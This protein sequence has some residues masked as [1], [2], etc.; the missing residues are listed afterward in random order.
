MEKGF[1]NLTTLVL[2][3]RRLKRDV[4]KDKECLLS[5]NLKMEKS[6]EQGFMN[7]DLK[8]RKAPNFIL[9]NK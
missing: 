5:L 6:L 7:L 3:R 1:L 4:R 9:T 8:A 2:R